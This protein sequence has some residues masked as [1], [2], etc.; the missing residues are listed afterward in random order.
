M[1]DKMR[2]LIISE[3]FRH[4]PEV[5]VATDVKNIKNLSEIKDFIRS[6]QYP[7]H[8]LEPIENEWGMLVTKTCRIRFIVIQPERLNSL[9]L[10][11]DAIV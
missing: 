6:F 11:G 1:N 5:L 10:K 2:E 7:F 8:I 3:S 4:F 9:A